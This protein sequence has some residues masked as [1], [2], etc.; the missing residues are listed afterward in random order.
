M[1]SL[2]RNLSYVERSWQFFRVKDKQE[3][4]VAGKF[5]Q[6]KDQVVDHRLLILLTR[7]DLRQDAQTP[8]CRLKEYEVHTM[9]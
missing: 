1:I 4:V 7:M 8:K 5:D 9:C 2:C 3:L 6:E